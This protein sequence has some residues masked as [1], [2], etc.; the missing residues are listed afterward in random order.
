MPKLTANFIQTK[1]K[2]P[3]KGKLISIMTPNSL[4]WGSWCGKAQ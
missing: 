4:D 3:A 2:A 1:I